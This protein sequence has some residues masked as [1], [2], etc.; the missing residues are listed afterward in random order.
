[1]RKILLLLTLFVSYQIS[2]QVTILTENTNWSGDVTMDGKYVV[3][4]GATLTIAPGTVI[5][6]TQKADAVDASALV[7]AKGGK[8]MAEGTA[9]APII[10]TSELDP[11]TATDVAAGTFY[12]TGATIP[13]DDIS[14]YWGG[15]IILGKNVIGED[16]DSNTANTFGEENIEGIADQSWSIY[17]GEETNDDSGVLK[18][19]SIRHGGTSIGAGNEINGLTLGGVGNGTVIEN[20]EIVGNQ[21]DGIE[22]FGGNVDVTNLLIYAQGDDAI[23]IDEAYSGTVN[24]ALVVMG[25]D[26]DNP[27]E[28]DG[29]EDGEGGTNG[30]VTGS[31]TISN[32]TVIGF[33]NPNSGFYGDFKKDPMGANNNIVFKGFDSGTIFKG[34][35]SDTF[36]TNEST[37]SNLD[38]ITDDTLEQVTAEAIF[39]DNDNLTGT[40]PSGLTSANAEVITVAQGQKEATGAATCVF[41]GWTAYA[42][43]DNA[44]CGTTTVGDGTVTIYT[45]DATWG[46]DVTMDG[47]LVIEDGATL[48]IAP[49]TVIKATQKADAV[50]ASALVVA[51]G[52]KIMAEG[53]ADAPIIFTS[54][55]DPLTATDVAA[56]TFYLTGATIPLDDISGYWGGLIILG[57][58]VIGEDPDSNTANTFG[59]ENIEG[60]ADQ[61]WSIYGGEETNDDSGVLK[62]VSIRHGGT[63][64]GAGNEI[65]GLTLGGVGNGTVIENIEI[66]GNQDDGIELFGGNVDVTN[67]LIYAQGDDAIDIDEAYSG[68][69]NNALVVMGTDSDNP[70]EIDGTEDGEGGTNGTVTGSYTI[71]NVTV[72]GFS[73]PNSGFYGDFK[74]D[75]MGANNNI[76]FKGFDSG[77]IFKGID[78]DTFETNESTFSNLDFITDD[79]LEQ[80]TA[81]AIFDDN[82]NLT[83]TKPSGLTSANAEVRTVAQGQLA[84]TGAVTCSIFDWT[85]VATTSVELCPQLSN[86]NFETS[87]FSVYP[88]PVKDFLTVKSN[89]VIKN[90]AVYAITGKKVIEVSNTNSVNLSKLNKG[91]YLVEIKGETSQKTK[92]IIIE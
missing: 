2:A 70:F 39:D 49:G 9:D 83:G 92:K 52:G 19:V 23:D 3:E 38:F 62:Y 10:F 37:F 43:L 8:I 75:P 31:Y 18:Y 68:T 22:L 12:L 63:S 60:I 78:S 55:L 87:N 17:G 33:S 57:K 13:L 24:N 7:V 34:I 67:L 46:G 81:E 27:F 54:E 4:N 91:L 71:S 47:K 82:D 77:T 29:T 26:S 20:I 32:V 89:E 35:D 84:N 73:N 80:V 86:K 41:E 11:L 25:T 44:L 16:P 30:T 69:V 65:N 72:I 45:E 5:K 36:E 6:A 74:K 42:T 79:T 1:M 85:A 40:K 59:E 88:N 51:K 58:N 21:D 14:G 90:I 28:I 48:Y 61:S 56:G 50:D 15:L 53:T 66:V 64:I 76:V